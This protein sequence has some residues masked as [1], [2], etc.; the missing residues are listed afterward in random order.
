M[1]PSPRRQNRLR[2]ALKLIGGVFG[3]L[4]LMIAAG[5]AW[6][7]T[8]LPDHDGRIELAGLSGP[9][10]ILRDA[11]GVPTIRAETLHDAYTG[12]GFV[13]AQDRLWQMEG[14][15]RIGAGRGAE[16]FG[17]SEF[18]L[19]SDRAMRTLGLYRLAESSFA[20]IS[21]ETR[22]A[23]EAYA[24]GVNGYLAQDRPWWQAPPPEFLLTRHEIAPW[25]PADS[26]LWGRLM[27]IRLTSDWRQELLRA[28]I[29]AQAPAAKVALLFPD[30]RKRSP[31]TGTLEHALRYPDAESLGDVARGLIE[32]WPDTLAPHL[33]SNAFA[34]AG[35]A[36]E[37]GGA[38]LANDPHLGFTAPGLWYLARLETPEGIR[39]G[40]TAPGVPF[41]V[42]GHNGDM[43]WGLTT[44][45]SDVTNVSI[46]PA[47]VLEAE[48]DL[49]TTRTERIEIK[50]GPPEP[51]EIRTTP[52]GI[53]VSDLLPQRTA[54]LRLDGADREIDDTFEVLLDSPAL[55]EDDRTAQSLYELNAAR[56]YE[57][58]KNALRNFHAPQQ[59]VFMAF[60]DGRIAFLS[61]GRVPLRPAGADTGVRLID[62]LQP[63][64]QSFW[65][66]FSRLPGTVTANGFIGN[67]NNPVSPPDYPFELA[68]TG[69]PPYRGDRIF[70][71][72]R[73]LKQAGPAEF[74]SL[75]Q[76]SVSLM[77]PALLPVLD[78]LLE[79]DGHELRVAAR[80]MLNEWNGAMLPGRPEPLIFS[81]WIGRIKARLIDDEF[82]ALSG[83]WD[84]P[85]D[86]LANV[87]TDPDGY[88][89][90]SPGPDGERTG[91][92]CAVLVGESL[93]TALD[94][95]IDRFGSDMS[96]WRWGDGHRAVFRH[97]PFGYVPVLNRLAN[98]E[99]ATAGGDH[100][101]NRGTFL[102][103]LEEN[104]GVAFPHR[105]GPGLRMIIDM[106]RPEAARFMTATGQSGN[107]LSG[108]YRTFAEGWA[109]GE[110]RP[111]TGTD[112][113]AAT[114]RLVLEPGV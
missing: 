10:E 62:S 114:A 108:Q 22:T 13:H 95:L 8:S 71:E 61:A 68:E 39:A 26:L 77:V 49:V 91:T 27:A 83:Y 103:R 67:G 59:N 52:G 109:R 20:H 99:V 45:A 4:V 50:G 97:Q 54:R 105:H 31:V 107:P 55:A 16:M 100:T 79:T 30:R 90:G 82:G 73:R 1:R 12:L 53:V 88:W 106:S 23:L 18:L 86:A 15:R 14:M 89:C 63:A 70:A 44:T 81:A 51:I 42:I 48:A 102:D 7:H 58:A 19:R 21:A 43:A 28:A 111:L 64:R 34:A 24:R 47:E 69:Y 37:T 57:D 32:V 36:S 17:G 84:L 72:L 93:D 29:A 38:L 65:V 87:L 6:L 66:P 76:D 5:F 98:I 46:I 33:A 101:V 40:A 2:L 112:P 75:Q 35:D 56:S 113:E 25:R 94:L 110:M 85:D 9:V 60:S 96:D 104:R 41:T 80:D 74:E 11:A 92:D 3:V 78:R